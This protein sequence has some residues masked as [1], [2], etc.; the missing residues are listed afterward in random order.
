MCFLDAT[1]AV[2]DKG[3]FSSWSTRARFAGS[4]LAPECREHSFER[5]VPILYVVIETL[6]GIKRHD[7]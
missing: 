4:K 2:I 3:F 1:A 5:L 7:G 6:F